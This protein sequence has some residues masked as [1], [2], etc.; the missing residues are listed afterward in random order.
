MRRGETCGTRGEGSQDL[1]DAEV[2]H[3][4]FWLYR[5]GAE[6]PLMLFQAGR[7]CKT[8]TREQVTYCLR[9]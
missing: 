8:W 9:R 1:E 5:N 6:L 4:L 7:G 3:K 2:L